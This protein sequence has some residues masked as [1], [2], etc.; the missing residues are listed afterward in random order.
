M[1]APLEPPPAFGHQLRQYFGF[2]SN[3]VNLNHGSYG[4]VPIPV[5][6]ASQA[7]FTFMEKNIDRF[8][9]LHLPEYLRPARHRMAEFVG[10]GP[11]EI[12]FV[13]NA[14]HG[15]N[16]VLR[17]L[18]W[19]KGDI[20]VTAT[21]TFLSLERTAQYIS[22]SP[23]HPSV[24]VFQVNFPTT[25]A[26]VLQ[27]FRVHVDTLSSKVQ[28]KQRE[29]GDGTKLKIVAVIDSIV[30][31]PGVHLPWKEMVAICRE[32]GILTVVD[33]AHSVGQEPN[34]NLKEADPDFWI[35]NCHKWLYAKRAC[36]ILYVPKR[37]QHLIRSTFPTPYNY[38]SPNESPETHGESHFAEMFGWTGTTDFT[39]YLSIQPA[40]H[41]REWLGGE[42]KI[43][44]YCHSLAL[45]GGKLLSKLLGTPLLD[46]T[47]EFTL[48]MVNVGLP[49]APSI[50][51]NGNTLGFLLHN[52]IECWH[53]SAA[54]FQHNGRWWVRASAQVW[55]EISDFDYLSRA[56]KDSCEKLELRYRR[57]GSAK[58]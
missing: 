10:A 9:R 13:P 38:I 16:T 4:S 37:N 43:N 28:A 40:L 5:S 1:T 58:L 17:N 41:F 56:L 42:Q 24:S 44:D 27:N 3:Y 47:G 14:S 22:D 15:T 49:L 39:H 33:A 51:D 18:V 25:R 36:A 46:P 2:E 26:S 45:S 35:S 8:I 48:N 55:N 21:T 29:I 34:I 11:D 12:V 57:N 53:V 54:V 52:L 31:N 7:T 20:I 30:S 23:P 6:A 19:N 50:P 32:R